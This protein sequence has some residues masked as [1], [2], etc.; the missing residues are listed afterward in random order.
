MPRRRIIIK[1][2]WQADPIYNSIAATR[3][4]NNLMKDGKKAKAQ[5]IF[6]SAIDYIREKTGQDGFKIFQQALKNTMPVVEV[7]PRKIAGASY[8]VPRVVSP[9]RRFYKA[10]KWIISAA[11]SK[12]GKPMYIRLAEEIISAYNNEGDAIKKKLEIQKQAEA[13]RAFAHFAWWGRKSKKK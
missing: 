8:L 11:R 12:K 7:W 10:V 5:K 9:E 3:F 6:Y 1:R 2:T 13:N 4:I